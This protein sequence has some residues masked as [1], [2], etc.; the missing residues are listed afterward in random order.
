MAARAALLM[1]AVTAAPNGKFSLTFSTSFSEYAAPLVVHALCAHLIC[2]LRMRRAN[3]GNTEQGTGQWF[4]SW[5]T[6]Q[7][8]IDRTNGAIDR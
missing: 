8:R 5:P 4:Y 3:F 7:L 6:Q 1:V 2:P